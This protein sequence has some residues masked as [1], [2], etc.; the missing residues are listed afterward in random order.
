MLIKSQIDVLLSSHT[1]EHFTVTNALFKN[2]TK[3]SEIA[4]I[5]KAPDYSKT[6][7]FLNRYSHM[8]IAKWI[9][10]W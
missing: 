1:S 8:R 7:R 9:P 5:S 6:R 10:T 2:A 3:I 4:H